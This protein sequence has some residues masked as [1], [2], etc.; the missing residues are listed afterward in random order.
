M[1]ECWTCEVEPESTAQDAPEDALS[2]LRERAGEAASEFGR[3][4]RVAAETVALLVI[5]ALPWLFRGATVAL[6]AWAAS[7]AYPSLYQALGGD[8]PAA[9]LA[10]A[11][12]LLP[13]AGA[14]GAAQG[15]RAEPW[16]AF[17]AAGVATYT[18]GLLARW[19]SPVA[20]A[21]AVG[22]GLVGIVVHFVTRTEVNHAEQQ[23]PR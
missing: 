19:A 16:G 3:L 9:P 4:L 7:C 14:L 6:A 20:V 5:I 8:P 13:L 21:L 23:G 2:G 10:L 15:A 18:V 1:A 17:V 12:V 22:A 11:L